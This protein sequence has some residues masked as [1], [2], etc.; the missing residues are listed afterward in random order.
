MENN[1]VSCQNCEKQF[2]DSFQFC[3]HCGQKAKDDLTLGVLFYNTVSN[4][5]S[6]DARF[7][8]S[9][10]PLLFKPGYLA[11]RFIEGKRLLY[12]HPAQ[13]YLFV[14]VVFFF[15]I[16][17][18]VSD[19]ANKADLALKKE[20]E[21]SKIKANDSISKIKPAIDSI[22]INEAMK[23]LKKNQKALGL[24]DEE[25]KKTD[26]IIKSKNV[27]GDFFGTSFS[28]NEK[29]VDSLISIEADNET[30]Y[31]AMGMEENSSFM[32]KKLFEQILKFHKN[33]GAGTIIN[34]FFNSI[35]KV[36]FISRDLDND[37]TALPLL[38]SKGIVCFGMLL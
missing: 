3:P 19:L 29:K 18:S 14:S 38:L 12:L 32:K 8:K 33:R 36:K 23:S 1:Q 7:F 24:N 21:R 26:S 11:S 10:F 22:Q 2:D 6:F 27:N 5:F 20:K 15:I 31:K 4:Y 30:I 16:S 34:T 35:P 17:F 37:S 13:L 28:Y 25:L 9:F